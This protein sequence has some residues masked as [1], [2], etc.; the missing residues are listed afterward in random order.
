MPPDDKHE[1]KVVPLKAGAP[2]YGGALLPHPT[3]VQECE[4]LLALA[5]SGKLRGLAA[6]CLDENFQLTTVACGDRG[7]LALLGGLELCR[8]VLVQASLEASKDLTL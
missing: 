2:I 7:N 6:A 8:A 5:K 3:V 1:E 4:Q